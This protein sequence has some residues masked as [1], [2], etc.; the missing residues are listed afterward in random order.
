MAIDTADTFPNHVSVTLAGGQ[1]P[2]SGTGTSGDPWLFD[3]GDEVT[4]EW[5]VFETNSIT[6][7]TGQSTPVAPGGDLVLTNSLGTGDYASTTI[8]S[9]SKVNFK[10]QA[11]STLGQHNSGFFTV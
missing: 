7:I 2:D 1:Q 4:D 8:G 9:G 6:G 3:S 11:P 10:I 5:Y